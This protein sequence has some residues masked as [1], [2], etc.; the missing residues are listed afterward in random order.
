LVKDLKNLKNQN[1]SLKGI[2]LSDRKQI[3]KLYNTIQENNKLITS[4]DF[5]NSPNINSSKN[6]HA[7][8]NTELINLKKDN[9]LRRNKIITKENQLKEEIRKK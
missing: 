8:I 2:I 1:E 9:N 3:M 6:F 5:P 7:N 4:M